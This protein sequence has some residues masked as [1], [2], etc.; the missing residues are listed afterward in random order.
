MEKITLNWIGEK[1][2]VQTKNGMVD[3]MSVKAKEYEDKYLGV[4]CNAYTDSWQVGQVVE[5]LKVEKVEKTGQDGSIKTYYNIKLPGKEDKTSK[6]IEEILNDIS[7]LKIEQTQI[8]KA[9]KELLP[10]E[11]DDYPENNLGESPF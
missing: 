2:Q 8:K 9:I 6:Q 1:S 10:P 7:Y 11:K 4:F 3:K 5:I